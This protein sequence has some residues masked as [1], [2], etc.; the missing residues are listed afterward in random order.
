MARTAEYSIKGYLYQFLRYLSEILA[1]EDGTTVTIEGAIEDIDIAAPGLT[2]AVQCKY[3]EQ[4]DK[5]TLG[6]IYKPILLMLEHFSK[7]A[8]PTPEV[9]YRLFCHFPGESGTRSLSKTEIDSVLATSA[10]GLKPIVARIA[11]NVD[12]DL[13]RKRLTIE[14]GQTAEELQKAVV[15]SLKGKGF[16][17]GDVEAIIYPNAIQQIVDLATQSTV[18]DRTV[19]PATFLAAL[20]DVRQV[21]FTRWTRELATRAQ[22][23]Q[24]L[25]KDLK[26]SLGQNSRGRHFVMDPVSIDKFDDDIVRFIKKFVES[27]SCKYLHAN[28]P[29]FTFT[30]DYNVG[31]LQTRL[32]D[33]GLRCADGLVGGTEF[34]AKELFRHPLR[35]KSPLMLEFRLRLA[36]R[37]S[38][39]EEPPKRPDELFLVNVPEDPWA[40]PDINVHR[41]EIERLSDLEYALQLRNEYA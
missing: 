40:H 30:G 17:D 25:R 28:P 34:R 15:S 19:N 5:F 33:A 20:H 24:R 11:A 31:A 4:V 32:H 6:K 21:T 3:H 14:F 38:V 18:L 23:F 16:S 41:F 10:E 35:Q 37:D 26:A 7:N 36:R 1:A 8:A 29:L 22:I 12:H 39:T 2:T 9:H 13:F 27:Y